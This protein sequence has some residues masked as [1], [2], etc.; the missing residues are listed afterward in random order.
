M[1]KNAIVLIEQAIFIR[2]VCITIVNREKDHTISL[3]G[4]LE[5]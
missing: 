2:D 1:I 5:S 3:Q 4:F